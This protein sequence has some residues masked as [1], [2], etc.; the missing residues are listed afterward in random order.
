MLVV[1]CRMVVMRVVVGSHGRGG[2]SGGGDTNDGIMIGSC[3]DGRCISGGLLVA[4][5]SRGDGGDGGW[6]SV[7][8][9]SVWQTVED[10]DG[11]CGCCSGS[12]VEN[13]DNVDGSGDG[14]M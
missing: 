4:G 6:G 12:G 14:W 13:C 5:D 8:V 1:V 11:C 7:I 9:G 10:E 3:H 2:G